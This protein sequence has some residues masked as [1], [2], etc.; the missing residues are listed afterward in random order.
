MQRGNLSTRP[1]YNERLV[2]VALAVLALL[3]AAATVFNVQRLVLLTARER[4]LAGQIASA[5]GEAQTLQQEAQRVRLGVNPE[6]LELVAARATEANAL[7]DQRRFSWTA[8]FNQLEAAIPDDVMLEAVQPSI[9]KGVTTVTLIVVGRSVAA[10][11]AFMERLED[12]GAFA[13]VL[14]TEEQ[15]TDAGTYRATLGG[16][17]WPER[18]K[19]GGSSTPEVEFA[20]VAAVEAVAPPQEGAR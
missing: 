18:A 6:E 10:I 12:T 8:L 11:D 4:T 9:D 14:S 7:I 2:H 13:G 3:V 5:D 16:Q 19:V 17:Y 15:V 1:F 20:P